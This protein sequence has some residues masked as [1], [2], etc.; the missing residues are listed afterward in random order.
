MLRHPDWTVAIGAIRPCYRVAPAPPISPRRRSGVA[1]S[2]NLLSAS[3]KLAI[4]GK[5][6]LA[7][8]TNE[9]GETSETRQ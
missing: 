4:Y 1:V 9:K 5:T 7:R 6:M 2:A 8:E 3:N